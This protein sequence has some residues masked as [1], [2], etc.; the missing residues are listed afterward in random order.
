MSDL[1]RVLIVDDSRMVRTSLARHLK[2][3]YEVKEEGDGEAAWQTLVLDHTI[4]AVISDLQMP[5]L[6]GFGL[7]ERV[8]A[9][10]LARLRDIPFVLIS[11]EDDQEVLDRA[12]KL[13][14]S[15]FIGKGISAVE[16][17]TRL[18]HLLQFAATRQNLEEARAQQVQD[19]VTGL[20]TRK[21]V[22]L[23]AAQALSHA[24][25]HHGEASVMVIGFDGYPALVEQIGHAKAAEMG[26]KF[27]KLVAGKI[28]R[29]DSLGHFEDGRFA[30]VSPGTSP[31]ACIAF[32]DRVRRA[33]ADSVVSSGGK[34]LALTMSV[35]VA[36][37]PVDRVISA[38]SLLTLAA[39]RMEAAMAA[40]GNRTESGDLAEHVPVLPLTMNQ[41]LELLRDQRPEA[42]VKQLGR[43]GQ[44]L[45]PMLQLLQQE[46][47]VDLPLDVLEKRLADRE[48]QQAQPD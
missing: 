44:Q 38:S 3:I 9:C 7:L 47:G 21:Y 27:A 28:R 32:A 46:L 33:V 35:G 45:L 29:E 19:A 36:S 18:G 2:G 20:F 25:R 24:F 5:V 39:S 26:V 12:E 40:G 8:R 30:I 42:V 41:A 31:G 14:V 4:A 10:K 22:E 13:G 16:L 1:P 6:D 34:R 37:V 15:D 11:G 48:Q 23:Q 17:K 43:L